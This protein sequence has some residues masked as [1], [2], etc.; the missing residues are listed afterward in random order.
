MIILE[1][2][3]IAVVAVVASAYVATQIVNA[4]ERWEKRG[5]R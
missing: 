2:I 1:A 4:W 3:G 5:K